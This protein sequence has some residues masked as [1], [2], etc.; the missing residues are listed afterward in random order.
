M[1]QRQV[2]GGMLIK[3]ERDV[4]IKTGA[5]K[6]KGLKRINQNKPVSIHHVLSCIIL[7]IFGVTL[8]VA[9]FCFEMMQSRPRILNDQPDG[10]DEPNL[11][12]VRIGTWVAYSHL[13]C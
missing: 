2:E 13:T 6:T 1:V 4:V 5:G 7:W 8:S 9:I 10:K 11:I 12:P 3:H